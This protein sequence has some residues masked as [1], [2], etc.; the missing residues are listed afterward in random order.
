MAQGGGGDR[1]RQLPRGAATGKM[2]REREERKSEERDR[3][4]GRRG[5]GEEGE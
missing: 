2:E 1:G 4:R 5:R 3:E